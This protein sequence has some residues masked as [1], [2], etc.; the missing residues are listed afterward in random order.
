MN[1]KKLL[2]LPL[3]F[4]LLF[5]IVSGCSGADTDPNGDPLESESPG[6]EN[7]PGAG[8]DL[9]PSNTGGIDFDFARSFFAPDTVMISADGVFVTW[10]ELYLFLFREISG[11]LYYFPD[12]VDWSEEYLPETTFADLI[13]EAAV[14][15]AL[16]L[17]SYAYGAKLLGLDQNSQSL[18]DFLAEIDEM[19]AD[20]GGV[21]V[22]EQVLHDNGFMSVEAYIEFAKLAMLPDLLLTHLYGEDLMGLS[23]DSIA[24]FAER[25][26]FMQAKHILVSHIS[27]GVENEHALE[28]SE[29]ILALLKDRENDD[30]FVD[31]FSELVAEYSEDPGSFSFPDGYLFVFEDMVPE[32]SEA[33]SNLNAGE[34]S[35]IVETSYG[36]HIIL[37]LPIN[38]DSI[39]AGL[40]SM[41]EYYTLREYVALVDFDELAYEWRNAVTFEFS[42]QFESIDFSEI[43]AWRE[44]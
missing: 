10:S 38:Y 13:L 44:Q 6:G 37:R 16:S 1:I 3:C 14:E 15:P 19:I 11:V 8:G 21:E 17:L 25:E 41:G 22:F 30:D 4:L 42:S 40:A 24:E 20:Y 5:A 28:D 34:I 9:D 27:D 23:D 31:Y 33:C 18:D 36:F 12:G 43:F 29:A 32:F 2:A 39:P 7:S 26:G 35:G